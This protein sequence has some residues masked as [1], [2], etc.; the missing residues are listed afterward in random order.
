MR[1]S[2]TGRRPPRASPPG[3][4]TLLEVLLALFIIG[5]AAVLLVEGYTQN[6][7]AINAN[8]LDTTLALLA[9]WK[10]SEI[11]AG[12]VPIEMHEEGTF[13]EDGYPD[14]QWLIETTPTETPGLSEVSVAVRPAGE[15][16]DRQFTLHRLV[17]RPGEVEEVGR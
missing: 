7:R 3:G 5:A 8:R 9:Q 4:F 1:T 11:A 2:R 15:Q 16:S 12:M 14:Y 6:L 13:E 10:M 17:Y